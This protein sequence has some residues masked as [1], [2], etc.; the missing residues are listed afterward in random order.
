MI[1]ACL[2]C[3]IGLTTLV[4]AQ[5]ELPVHVNLTSRALYLRSANHK[6]RRWTDVRIQ[7]NER[8]QF[9][10]PATPVSTTVCVDLSAFDGPRKLEFDPLQKMDVKLS[11]PN[12][13]SSINSLKLSSRDRA[14]TCLH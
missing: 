8:W 3:L 7:L 2:V 13:V 5:P 12:V 9:T 11:T 10:L 6:A 1:R 4:S 14:T